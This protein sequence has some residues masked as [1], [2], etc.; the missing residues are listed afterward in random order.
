M[1]TG[2]VHA[3]D[4]LCSKVQGQNLV[5]DTEK[6]DLALRILINTIQT[7]DAFNYLKKKGGWGL[8]VRFVFQ[9]LF[10]TF[11]SVLLQKKPDLLALLC[12]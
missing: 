1:C 11:I 5:S 2:N 9:S 8:K 6:L 3:E 10:L 4:N 7:Q 12:L